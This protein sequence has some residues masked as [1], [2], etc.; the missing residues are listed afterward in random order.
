[1]GKNFCKVENKWCKHLSHNI[2]KKA[3]CPLIDVCRCPRLAEIETV[4]LS[5][6]IKNAS[7][8]N[9]CKAMMKWW[10]DQETSKESYKDVFAK[11][12]VMTP[13]KHNLNDM[14]IDVSIVEE[15]GKDYLDVTGMELSNPNKS[16]A[17]EFVPWIEWISMFIT[18]KTLNIL[19]NDEIIA[20][21][22]YEMTWSGFTEKQ[23]NSKLETLINA[24]DEC[25][26]NKI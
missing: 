13:K 11:L 20:G 26:K 19:S 6:L 25:K 15:D 16:Y 17:I 24:V 12:S 22:L 3:D 1:M 8:E 18:K 10:P 4:R 21:C 2:C 5:E 9:I 7:F 23:I 14:F